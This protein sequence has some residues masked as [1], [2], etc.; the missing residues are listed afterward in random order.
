MGAG[1][2]RCGVD[3]RG[4]NCWD[5]SL[6]LPW[7]R[8]TVR[9][10][11]QGTVVSSPPFAGP[12]HPCDRIGPS[13]GTVGRSQWDKLAANESRAALPAAVDRP[14]VKLGRLGQ[15][16]HSSRTAEPSL[17]AVPR[18]RLCGHSSTLLGGSDRTAANRR[19]QRR[20]PLPFIQ[21]RALR[22]CVH[23]AA[24]VAQSP[25]TRHTTSMQS[26]TRALHLCVLLIILAVTWSHTTGTAAQNKQKAV[27]GDVI[28][29][30]AARGA[31]PSQA[32]RIRYVRATKWG[33]GD[34]A[35]GL[36]ASMRRAVR[37]L[38]RQLGRQ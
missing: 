2:S 16:R 12:T 19:A 32:R 22:L 33:G 34:G 35:V 14:A 4:G 24:A 29:W 37:P 25:S 17:T 9:E 38:P 3:E 20:C 13:V 15:R 21:A 31:P 7:V 26:A 23:C 5:G 27:D 30:R 10:R 28:P 6:R 36:A 1:R 18:R 8:Q 11:R